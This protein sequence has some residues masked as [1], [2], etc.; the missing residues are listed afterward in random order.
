MLRLKLTKFE[1]A[2]IAVTVCFAAVAVFLGF[3]GR[4]QVPTEETA[5]VSFEYVDQRVDINYAS[6]DSL[7]T[8]PGI[9]EKT[10]EKIIEYRRVHDGFDS[11]EDILNVPG[12]GEKKFEDIRELIKVE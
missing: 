6:A 5:L 2:V 4:T 9:G 3:Y 12:I 1:I 7:Q 10:A 8:L 11:I